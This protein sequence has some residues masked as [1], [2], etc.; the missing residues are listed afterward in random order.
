MHPISRIV[1]CKIFFLLL[2]TPHLQAQ[3]WNFVK[4]KDG[5]KIY[6]R[7]PENSSFKC[8]KG[9]TVFHAGMQKLGLYI[10]NVR[11]FD[12]WDKNIREL[13][14]LDSETDKEIQYYFIY[15]TPW[16]LNDRDFC[17]EVFITLDTLSGEKVIYAR[18][19]P[20]VIPER[21]GIVR[22][23]NY[24]QKWT[25]R[26]IDKNSV[27]GILEGFVD[28]GGTVPSWLYNMVIVETPL[29]IMEGIKQKVEAKDMVK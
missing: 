27:Y 5:I 2:I 14:V 24:W 23:K 18:P 10:G 19:L 25:L 13:R 1:S 29:R 8:Y 4:E 12:W 20:G 11:N 3:S 9:E 26:P 21:Q 17:V 28:P 7:T 15:H 22:I 6:T 16:P